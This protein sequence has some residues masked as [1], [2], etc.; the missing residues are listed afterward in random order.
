M[1]N[2]IKVE[3]IKYHDNDEALLTMYEHHSHNN[4]SCHH[5]R[6]YEN[7]KPVEPELIAILVLPNMGKRLIY[8]SCASCLLC[9]CNRLQWNRTILCEEVC[10]VVIAAGHCWLHGLAHTNQDYIS[11]LGC[12]SSH[13]WPPNQ[14]TQILMQKDIWWK[15]EG[16]TVVGRI[17]VVG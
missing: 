16:A 12:C 14:C 10:P 1:F 11:T 4:T 8:K 6:Q 13:W 17:T 2:T 5:A 9:G 3:V 15:K 7:P